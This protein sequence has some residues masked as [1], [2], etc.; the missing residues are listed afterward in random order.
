VKN[1]E[2]I[3]PE[4][5]A[6]MLKSENDRMNLWV[7][8]L[9][10][11]GD[12]LADPNSLLQMATDVAVEKL[13]TRLEVNPGNIRTPLGLM[14][15]YQSVLVKEGLS[16][17]DKVTFASLE[18]G[19]I[20]MEVAQG[21]PY[22][23]TCHLRTKKKR[24]CKRVLTFVSVIRE[25]LSK[26]YDY[27]LVE[28]DPSAKCTCE[29]FPSSKLR[30]QLFTKIQVVN[31]LR[32]FSEEMER[33]QEGSVERAGRYYAQR[34]NGDMQTCLEQFGASGLGKIELEG[35]KDKNQQV[36]FK[37]SDLLQG[38]G[39][40]STRA[41][42]EF[43]RGFLAGVV[44]RISN[45]EVNCEEVDCVAKGDNS[46]RFIVTSTR[47]TEQ[48]NLAQLKMVSMR[49]GYLPN[50]DHLTL[51]VANELL[52]PN[53]SLMK[54]E[55]KRFSF[56]RELNQAVA[57][58]H[59]DGGFMTLPMVLA[60]RQQG[61]QLKVVGLGN[62]N[63]S[64]LVV[65]HGFEEKSKSI[66]DNQNQLLIAIPNK[67][68]IE[69]LLLQKWMNKAGLPFRTV[70]IPSA[71]IMFNLENGEIDGYMC[72]EPFASMAEQEGIGSRLASSKEIWPNHMGCVMVV[73]QGFY[74]RNVEVV[75]ELGKQIGIAGSIIEND[76]LW[77]SK[78]TAQYF[79]LLEETAHNCLLGDK[80]KILYINLKP[81][82]KEF[83][84][85]QDL[86]LKMDLMT[87]MCSLSDLIID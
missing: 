40:T 41:V 34:L 74:N 5:L 59:L 83:E 28:A 42:D 54:V 69:S 63:G 15:W 84:V 71:N 72:N 32:I 9:E 46:C 16:G 19:R 31:L 33:L 13:L 26:E 4:E 17:K 48:I 56:W 78:I 86:L 21:C 44:S 82:I 66:Q 55:I 18:A 25:Y 24:V 1:L 76:R 22:A 68:S 45:V 58:G 37:G 62:R 38:I 49:L 47:S 67:L 11:I 10:C 85:I 29:L 64:G 30:P 80:E 75:R 61:V 87:E 57:E 81:D 43:T 60:Y 77:A 12:D 53:N 35:L 8:A 2:K 65:S 3:L 73:N 14:Q 6:Y 50:M 51:P 52:F 7:H 23:L 39:T 79:N 36:T 27:V 70:S 20:R